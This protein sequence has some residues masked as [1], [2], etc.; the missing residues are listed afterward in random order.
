MPARTQAR[1]QFIE[2]AAG[3]W[4]LQIIGQALHQPGEKNIIIQGFGAIGHAVALALIKEKNNI[5][6]RAITQFQTAQ[7]AKADD[8]KSGQTA[9]FAAR[10]AVFVRQLRI[11]ALIGALQHQ[12]GNP[13]QIIAHF[14]QRQTAM[15]IAPRHFKHLHML[16][17]AQS[18][19]PDFIILHPVET[20]RQI[21]GQT[22]TFANHAA[23]AQHFIEHQR[24]LAN[25]RHQPART[26]GNGEQMGEQGLLFGKHADIDFAP[27]H[28]F[29][30]RG[31][32]VESL[33]IFR[34]GGNQ[35]EQLRQQFF[36]AARGFV[37]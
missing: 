32:T 35:G 9:V 14:H 23:L 30:Q 25:K 22:R 15:H 13:A 16:E 26:G 17:I 28:R 20:R 6:I 27:R 21:F 33:G 24:M 34:V 31:N 5:Q 37:R 4:R 19:E 12:G 8:G 11:G 3:R 2:H 1:I 10:F 18:G 7:F 36:N 29:H